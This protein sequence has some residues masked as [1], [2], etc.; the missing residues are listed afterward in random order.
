M[1]FFSYSFLLADMS[2]QTRI[3]WNPH[4][5]P[6]PRACDLWVGLSPHCPALCWHP[7]CRE[8]GTQAPHLISDLCVV[9]RDWLGLFV[10]GSAGGFTLS[11]SFSWQDLT[12]KHYLLLWSL[13]VCVTNVINICT[14]ESWFPNEAAKWRCI[15]SVQLSLQ[16]SKGCAK[17]AAWMQIHPE[18]LLP[19]SATRKK[20][21]EKSIVTVWKPN[22]W[23]IITWTSY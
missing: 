2:P 5:D 4:Y 12:P 16:W 13:C 11:F 9:A 21:N 18:A 23:K 15:D 7:A 8:E 1:L 19:S 22:D 6:T 14:W 3:Q 10:S 17:W 20:N